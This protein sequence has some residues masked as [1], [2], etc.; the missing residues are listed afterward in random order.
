MAD[1]LQLSDSQLFEIERLRRA[2]D[3]TDDVRTLQA[4]AKEFLKL[5]QTQRAATVWAIRVGTEPFAK[6]TPSDVE[7]ELG[8]ARAAADQV[9]GLE[10]LMR[11]PED[12][13][14]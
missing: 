1:P 3:A 8:K 2:I 10:R 5:W 13:E 9:A 7:A 14:S 12:D 6:V 11:E 4:M